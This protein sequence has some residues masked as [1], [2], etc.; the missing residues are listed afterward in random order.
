MFDFTDVRQICQLLSLLPM[1]AYFI[2]SGRCKWR[3]L[4]GQ[5]PSVAARWDQ[6]WLKSPAGGGFGKHQG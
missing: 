2:E 3:L 1:I 4:F 5:R 6:T